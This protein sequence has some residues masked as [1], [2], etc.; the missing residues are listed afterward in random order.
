MTTSI[1]ELFSIPLIYRIDLSPDGRTLL[2]SSNAPGAAHLHISQTKHGSKPKQIT[3]GNDPVRF[4]FLSPSGN[5]VLYLLDK[6]GNALHH[7][8]L[9]SEDGIN[10]RRITKEPCRTWSACWDPRGKEIARSI[11]EH[12]DPFRNPYMY[13]ER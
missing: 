13:E 8:F 7:L 3:H 11:D 6:D 10:T 5:Q 2:C 4:G 9:T 1:N 12:F